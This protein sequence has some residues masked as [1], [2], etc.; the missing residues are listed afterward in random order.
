MFARNVWIVT[1]SENC[2]L[3]GK[4][5]IIVVKSSD[6]AV[7]ILNKSPSDIWQQLQKI[8]FIYVFAI[9]IAN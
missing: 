2:L 4:M 3:I 6:T 1:M 7:K 8:L 5:I 9:I